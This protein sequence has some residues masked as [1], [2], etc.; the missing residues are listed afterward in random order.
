MVN[1]LYD[2]HADVSDEKRDMRAF[3]NIIPENIL[4]H[5]HY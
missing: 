2:L 3:N 1:W 5:S 4:G